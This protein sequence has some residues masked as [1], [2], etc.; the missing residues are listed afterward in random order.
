M[1]GFEF[2]INSFVSSKSN[3]SAS[4]L[5]AQ[6]NCLMLGFLPSMLFTDVPTRPLL[7]KI[8]TFTELHSNYFIY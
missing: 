1:S 2:S 7:P 3:K 8:K 4:F 6:I 5:V